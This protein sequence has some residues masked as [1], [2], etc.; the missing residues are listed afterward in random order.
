MKVCQ[1]RIT[2][3]PAKK[4]VRGLILTSP[5]FVDFFALAPIC[6]WPERG[7]NS[8]LR[9]VAYLKGS[10]RKESNK[11]TWE[12]LVTGLCRFIRIRYLR[13]TYYLKKKC[14]GFRSPFDY[15]KQM[16]RGATDLHERLYMNISKKASYLSTFHVH[17]KCTWN[18]LL[19][20]NPDS[21]IFFTS[22][23]W[24]S[25]YQFIGRPHWH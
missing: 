19:Q 10:S 2:L 3:G 1:W 8:E 24:K 11:Q 14:G 7:K 13:I 18:K 25:I 17:N 4:G 6:A 21:S 5:C 22:R 16:L 20:S 15:V 23:I 9:R 12:T